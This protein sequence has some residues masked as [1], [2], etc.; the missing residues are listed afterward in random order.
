MQ[1]NGIL[2]LM[3]LV[4]SSSV[5][6]HLHQCKRLSQSGPQSARHL[7]GPGFFTAAQS[8]CLCECAK[9]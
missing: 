6:T 1:T 2:S 9:E 5:G 4:P 8:G 7:Y 3:R